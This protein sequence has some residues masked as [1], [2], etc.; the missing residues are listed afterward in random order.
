MLI[1]PSCSHSVFFKRKCLALFQFQNLKAFFW[2]LSSNI[3]NN[4]NDNFFPGVFSPSES[5]QKNKHPLLIW[6]LTSHARTSNWR[7]TLQNPSKRTAWPSLVTNSSRL[8]FYEQKPTKQKTFEIVCL[9]WATRTKENSSFRTK[10]LRAI[11]IFFSPRYPLRLSLPSPR[12]FF[13]HLQNRDMW[14]TT[15]IYMG[16]LIKCD[17]YKKTTVYEKS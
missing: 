10:S 16:V 3:Q 6:E 17:N 12:N 15:Y 14:I 13:S 1:F 11:V 2:S 9:F 7:P 5:M 4:P 8:R